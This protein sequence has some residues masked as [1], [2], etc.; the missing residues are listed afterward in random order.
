[1]S[2]DKSYRKK[3][4]WRENK[5]VLGLA[6]NYEAWK[7]DLRDFLGESAHTMIALEEKEGKYDKSKHPQRLEQIVAHWDE[8]VRIIEE[9]LPSSAE[10][11]GLLTRL[12]IPVD[13]NAIS[14]D[15]DTARMTFL[16]TKDIRDKYVL[17]RLGW[18]LGILDELC[19]LL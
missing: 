15:S 9:E 18:D 13:L 19:A 2:P 12:H 1:M 4:M 3:N 5:V 7:N 14:V 6:R 10:L 11:E 8:I 16:C 17:A